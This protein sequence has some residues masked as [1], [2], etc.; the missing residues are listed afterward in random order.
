MNHSLAI[1]FP[2]QGSQCVGML[3]AVTEFP[4]VQ[5]IFARASQV[6][7][8]D[9]WELVTHGPVSELDKT[10][11]TQPALLA[12]G[13]AIWQIIQNRQAPKPAFLAG[14][15]LGEYT[16]LVCAEAMQFEEAIKLVGCTR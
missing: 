3:Q 6:L 13:Y 15:S 2:G 11:H 14:H 9:L 12:A 7:N 10:M 4:E 1:V 16:A 5:E 8:F